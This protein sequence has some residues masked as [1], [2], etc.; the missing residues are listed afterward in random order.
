MGKFRQLSLELWPLINII[1]CSYIELI[2]RGGV[3]CLPAALFFS[4]C[5]CR[6]YVVL[7]DAFL[8]HYFH[9]KD[10]LA[11][12]F[13][14]MLLPKIAYSQPTRDKLYNDSFIKDIFFF[15]V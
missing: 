14:T 12:V 3:S 2:F 8:L 1:L 10:L 4:I 11:H 7:S 15:I 6:K 9:F 13:V 5:I